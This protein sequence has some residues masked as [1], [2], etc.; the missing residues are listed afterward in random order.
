MILLPS[1]RGVAAMAA[2][3]SACASL[4]AIP[5]NDRFEF[6]ADLGNPAELLRQS[7]PRVASFEEFENSLELSEDSV[8][9]S[10]R[11]GSLWFRWTAPATATYRLIGLEAG[12]LVDVY[13]SSGGNLGAPVVP[14]EDEFLMKFAATAGQTFYFRHTA[15]TEVFNPF[16][17]PLVP[18]GFILRREGTAKLTDFGPRESLSAFL[19]SHGAANSEKYRWTVTQSGSYR[20]AVASFFDPEEEPSVGLVL[21]KNGGEVSGLELN[22]ILT[23]PLVA[24]DVME[25]TISG[26]ARFAPLSFV[27]EPSASPDLGSVTSAQVPS[28]PDLDYEWLWTAPANGYLKL[29]LSTPFTDNVLYFSEFEAF[30]YSLTYVTP[31]D[32]DAATLAYRVTL[33]EKVEAGVTYVFSDA[34]GSGSPVPGTIAL[35]F[36]SAPSTVAERVDA[37]SAELALETDASLLNADDHL[38]AALSIE[39]ANAHANAFRAFTRLALLEKE[40]AYTAFLQSLNITDEGPDIFHPKL[41]MPEA[42]EG[43]PLFSA[44]ANATDRIAAL[45]T[46][47][48]PRLT[49]IRGLL[50]ASVAV[51]DRRSYVAKLSQSYVIDEADILGMKASVDIV[52]ALLDLLAVYDL[53]GSLNAIVDLES[54][55]EIDLE[56]AVAEIPTLL[57]VANSAAIAEF[58]TKITNANNLL[59]AALIQSAGQRTVAGSHMF[60]PV[61]LLEGGD[62]LLQHMEGIEV[63]AKALLGPVKIGTETVDLTQWNSSSASLRSLLPALRGNRALGLTAPDPT[64]DGILPNMGLGRFDRLLESNRA[65]A[66]PAGF[67]LWIEGFLESGVPPHLA[68][69]LDDADGDGDTNGEE[70]YFASDPADPSIRVQTPVASLEAVPGGKSFRVSFVRRIGAADIRYVAA[71]SDNA[72]TW[73][74]T[75]AQVS[76]V[77]SPVPV[78]DGQGEIVTVGISANLK[79]TQFIRIHAVAN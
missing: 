28:A 25:V 45:R 8:P 35:K 10:A 66:D 38:A 24:G 26:N 2:A 75:Q 5:F 54:D 37:A 52:Q 42:P 33:V 77:G 16:F 18:G 56:R 41:I 67:S 76:V 47:L 13:Q 20:L 12:D 79:N 22:E 57:E 61:G 68:K 3:V 58:K 34:F 30:P 49:E 1:F 53:G 64:F 29:E 40:P 71:V 39:P 74:Y 7:D 32:G 51:D 78:G 72:T 44:A 31:L 62:D 11:S 65:L 9:L 69:F 50:N 36:F 59:C 55:G 14:D 21:R 23:L 6:A 27:P 63:L 60:P 48:S 73:D 46:L 17:G 43:E 19:T 4:H 15:W 70:Y